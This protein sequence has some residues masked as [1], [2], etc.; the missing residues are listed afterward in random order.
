[1]P[2]PRKKDPKKELI[3]I[4]FGEKVSIDFVEKI[5]V[6]NWYLV[7]NHHFNMESAQ[8]IPKNVKYKVMYERLAK[9]VTDLNT[10]VQNLNESVKVE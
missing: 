2:R 4:L 8:L 3:R 5:L 9:K 6:P 7:L 1:M 10:I